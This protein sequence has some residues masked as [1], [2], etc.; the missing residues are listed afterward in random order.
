MK[1]YFMIFIRLISNNLSDSSHKAVDL[2]VKKCFMLVKDFYR[3][4]K[5]IVK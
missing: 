3:I 2:I 1:S 5:N 4:S